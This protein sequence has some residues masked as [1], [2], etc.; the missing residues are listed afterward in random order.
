M[1]LMLSLPALAGPVDEAIRGQLEPMIRSQ[2]LQIADAAVPQGVAEFYAQRQWQPVW[3]EARYQAL[4]AALADM[5]T[6]GLDPDDYFLSELQRFPSGD[7][8]P[9]TSAKRDMLATHAYLLALVHLYHGKTDPQQLDPHWNFDARQFDPENGLTLAREAVEQNNLP[10]IFARA[11]PLAPQYDTLRAA[12]SRLRAMAQDGGWVTVPAGPT[13]KPGISDAR[14]ALLRQRLQEAQLMPA[15]AAEQ[16]ELYDPALVDAVRQFQRESYLDADGAVGP[17]TLAALNVPLQQR[18]DQVRVNLE[19]GRWLLHELEEQPSLVIV[20]IAGYRVS[21]LRDGEVI[22]RSRVQIGKEYRPTPVFESEITYITLSP[23]WV[24][25]PTIFRQ[26]TLPAI[27][28]DPGYL[29][30]NKLHVF[31]AAGQEIAASSVNWASPGNIT[32]R[33]EPGADGAL[34]EMAIRFPNPYAVYLHDTPHQELFN[35]SQR[36]TSSGCIRVEN[37]HELAVLLFNDQVKWNREAMQNVINERK[38]R[39]V[40]LAKPVPILLAYWT[41]DVGED[42]HVSFKPDVYQRDGRVL[43]ALNR[44]P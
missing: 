1:L 32:L 5:A 20:D 15:G 38:T 27:R 35:N 28:R 21:Y 6:D 31:N 4:L 12:L 43:A 2:P 41:V 22:W 11:R 33:Q 23:G 24:I 8:D 29:A 26:D 13:L 18:I 25:P 19:R 30:R 44:A 42:G 14:V 34:G 7:V 3:D 36:A 10:G 40:T 37:V 39:N 16:P 9:Q 17:Q